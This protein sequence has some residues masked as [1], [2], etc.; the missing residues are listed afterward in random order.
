MKK[1]I[2]K[3]YFI[4]IPLA[5]TAVCAALGLIR[6]IINDDTAMLKIAES[7][8]TNSHSEHLVFISVIFGYL[9]K[10]LYG[11]LPNINWFITLYLAVLNIGFIALCGVIKKLG[12]NILGYGVII[13]FQV[14]V[15]SN[16]TF[17]S[18]SFVCAVAGM[19]WML[20][21][22]RKL[23]KKSIIHFI[24]GFMLLFLAFAM[25]RGDTFYFTVLIFIPVYL[26]SFLKKRNSLAVIAALIVLCTAANYTV[27]GVQS[28]Y[29]DKIP[30]EVYFSEFRKYR[31]AANDGGLFNYERHGE[32]LQ[33]AGI[34]ENDYYLLRRW[35]FGDKKVYSAETMKA[36][37]ESRDFDEKYNTNIVEIAKNILKQN[38][39]LLLLAALI[40]MT[41]INI[42]IDKEA[43]L[44][45]LFVAAFTG[46]AF[47][48]LYFRRRGVER[49]SSMVLI[50][51]I[52]IMLCILLKNFD[53]LKELKPFKKMSKKAF[54]SAVV[55][56]C[57]LGI[58][59]TG[60]YCVREHR[61]FDR[62]A[63][64]FA[65]VV[66]YANDK[67]DNFYV[68]DVRVSSDYVVKYNNDNIFRP[69][70]NS[71]IKVYGFLGTWTLY[72][73]YYYDNM[74]NLGVE[75]YSDKLISLLLRDDVRF[76]TSKMPPKKFVRFFKENYGLDVEYKVVKK[77]PEG[78]YKIYKF[79]VKED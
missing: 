12:E 75:E 78:K 58:I 15:L 26:F 63:E 25:R 54:T 69:Y 41:L 13:A 38:T 49:V 11:I 66:E 44:E 1:I 39:V 64:R 46:A 14:F 16:L 43:R 60:L 50:S 32:E 65:E 27:V 34:T 56:V 52:L 70:A 61:R 62:K 3:Y 40:L 37:A 5:V 68:S 35:V 72:T 29:N 51:G 19:L 79:S 18:I 2:K 55:S 23:E 24:I 30:A 77:F 53:N 33:K 45:P 59:G 10:L 22:I 9:L 6:Y 48:F 73:Y 17:T 20:V 47:G 21:F 28:I 8:K 31:G 36:V 4:L 57:I 76:I 7:F 74:K 71:D 67:K 42:I